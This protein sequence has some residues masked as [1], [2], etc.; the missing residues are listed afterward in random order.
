LKA[1]PVAM[2]SA[3]VVLLLLGELDSETAAILLGIGLFSVGL[4]LLK[5]KNV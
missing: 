3:V 4:L 5:R 2:G 1:L